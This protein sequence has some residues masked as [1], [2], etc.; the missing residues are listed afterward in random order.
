MARDLGAALDHAHAHGVVHRDVKPAN[1]LLRRDGDHQARRPRHRHGGRPD[2]DHPQRR[3][4]RAPRRTWRP[5][6][7]RALEPR[8]A[9]DVY[10]LAAVCFEALAGRKAAQ[11]AHRRRDRAS[12]SQP[13]PRPT[14][15]SRLPGSSR[16]S[17]GAF[18]RNGPRSGERHRQSPAS[19]R[20]SSRPRSK[21]ANGR[22]A[23]RRSPRRR[24]V[25]PG[26]TPSALGRQPAAPASKPL[27]SARPAA[28]GPRRKATALIP[29]ALLAVVTGVVAVLL[30]SGGGSDGE[31]K[32]QQ[33]AGQRQ[34]ADRGAARET[35]AERPVKPK[36][37]RTAEEGRRAGAGGSDA[38]HAGDAGACRVPAGNR[39]YRQRRGAQ[40]PGLRADAARATTPA[41]CRSSSRPSPSWPDAVATSS[42]AYA[43]YNLGQ[44]AQPSGPRQLRRSPIWRSG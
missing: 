13:S 28:R 18:A 16:G 20:T 6:S 4:A 1:V 15:A 14:C 10:A 12:R 2:A 33:A 3:G 7:S 26:S 27:T 36:K 42:Y 39:R 11:G 41:P 25:C 29:V 21:G 34:S 23:W 32:S 19:W 24:V 37:A 17:R 22:L 38:R 9:S 30:L 31:P 35:S 44:V 40:R 43:L 8:P 5:S